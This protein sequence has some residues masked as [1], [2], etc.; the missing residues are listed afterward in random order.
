MAI[1]PRTLRAAAHVYCC[2]VLVSISLS[3][4]NPVRL[5]ASLRAGYGR[6]VETTSSSL[7]L[8]SNVSI[9]IDEAP[10]DPGSHNIKGCG[11]GARSCLIGGRLAFGS[12]DQVPKTYVSSITVSV[13]GHE[14]SLDVSQMYDAWGRRTLES[15]GMRYFGGS[16]A[17]AL[18]CTLRGLFS[19]AA[20]T[21]AAEWQIAGGVPVRTVLTD[22]GDVV[23]AFRQH[24]DPP[25]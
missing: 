20:A 15:N 14:Y 5:G 19:D 13:S 17:D 16:C 22:S 24:I 1:T 18:N 7:T 21:Y 12:A 6:P 8:P 9:R 25:K 4:C 23:A 10:F 11:G 2:T 3:A